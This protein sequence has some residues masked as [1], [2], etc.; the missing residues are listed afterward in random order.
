MG[1]RASV[2]A[3]YSFGKGPNEAFERQSLE[4]HRS[5]RASRVL[6]PL[7]G[8]FCVASSRQSSESLRQL[9]LLTPFPDKQTEAQRQKAPLTSLSLRGEVAAAGLELRSASCRPRP[10]GNNSCSQFPSPQLAQK[11]SPLSELPAQGVLS[12]LG[13]ANRFHLCY[14]LSTYC[15]LGP[16]PGP[17]C[18]SKLPGTQ[19]VPSQRGTGGHRAV[20]PGR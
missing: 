9:V 2:P 4:D 18:V 13:F 12:S 11:Y 10:P 5:P 3:T 20:C 17:G 14:L 15:V 6:S 1:P 8:R 7:L 19:L 16:E